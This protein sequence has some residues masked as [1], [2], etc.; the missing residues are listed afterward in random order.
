LGK[1]NGISSYIVKPIDRQKFIESIK[2]VLESSHFDSDESKTEQE[3]IQDFVETL[4]HIISRSRKYLGPKVSDKYLWLSRPDFK[5][6]NQFQMEANKIRYVEDKSCQRDLNEVHEHHLRKWLHKFLTQCSQT[7][8][9]FESELEPNDLE[10]IE[11][12]LGY[13]ILDEDASK[14]GQTLSSEPLLTWTESL[15]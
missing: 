10:F 14:M 13:T 2:L 15:A 12:L 11:K 5:W 3:Y 8:L 6:L 7:I 9:N 1:K 4:N